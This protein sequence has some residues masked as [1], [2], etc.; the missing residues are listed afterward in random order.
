MNENYYILYPAIHLIDH[1]GRRKMLIFSSLLVISMQ[2]II[3]PAIKLESAYV[4]MSYIAI[5]CILFHIIGYSSGLGPVP[6]VLIPEMYEQQ[7]RG[8]MCK[9]TFYLTLSLIGTCLFTLK[10]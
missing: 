6:Q 8:M 9:N 2:L 10:V 3:I 1:I 5:I 7:P 4:E